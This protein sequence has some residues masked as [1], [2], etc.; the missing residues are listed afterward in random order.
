MTIYAFIELSLDFAFLSGF[1][2]LLTNA[3]TFAVMS[4][5]IVGVVQSVLD[6]RKIRCACLGDV[7]NL[8]MSTIT[9]IEDALMIGMSAVMLLTML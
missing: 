9:I 7:F 8:P 3:V 5:S 4:V 1:N 6:K 2:P